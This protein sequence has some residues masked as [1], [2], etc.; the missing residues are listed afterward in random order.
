M[1]VSAKVSGLAQEAVLAIDQLFRWEREWKDLS[2]PERLERRRQQSRE[3]VL[4]F[5]RWLRIHHPQLLPQSPLAKACRYALNQWE[6]FTRFLEDG[7]LPLSN[8]AAERD[9]RPVAM[10][11]RNFF[12]VGSVRSG[13]AIAILLSLLRSAILCGLTIPGITS[14]TYSPA[15][16]RTRRPASPICF[17][18][19]GNLPDIHSGPIAWPHRPPLS[20]TSETGD[21]PPN[22][23][24][25]SGY[26]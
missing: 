14:R 22:L 13:E 20:R 11:R 6:A 25:P 4:A 10:G 12:Y 23:L 2:P 15:C 5:E 7:R 17:P 16:P 8:N 26:P 21:L 18:I 3:H 9:M 24:P 19:A 1:A